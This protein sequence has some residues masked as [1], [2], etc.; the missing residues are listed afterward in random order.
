M[1]MVTHILVLHS[2]KIVP[3][4]QSKSYLFCRFIETNARWREEVPKILIF[5]TD[6]RPQDRG[7]VPAAAQSLRDKGVRIFAIGVGDA[8]EAELKEIASTPYEDHVI[9]ISGGKIFKQSTISEI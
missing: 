2:G 4:P 3:R 9:F 6:G 8:T 1:N 5:I 7:Q